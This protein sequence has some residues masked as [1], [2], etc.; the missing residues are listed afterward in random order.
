MREAGSSDGV[1]NLP[2]LPFVGTIAT[3]LATL[4]ALKVA[5]RV[6]MVASK[7]SNCTTRRLA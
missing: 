5:A 6:R 4:H 2:S 7:L 1:R 3:V